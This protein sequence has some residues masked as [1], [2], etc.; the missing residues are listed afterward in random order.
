MSADENNRSL[1]EKQWKPVTT[2][3]KLNEAE[4]V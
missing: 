4:L 3:G 1:A 2:P